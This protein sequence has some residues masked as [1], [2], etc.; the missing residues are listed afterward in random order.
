[1]SDHATPAASAVRAHH[2]GTMAAGVAVLLALSV[3]PPASAASATGHVSV[4][5][6]PA[7]AVIESTPVDFSVISRHTASGGITLSPAGTVRLS[8]APHTVVTLSVGPGDGFAHSGTAISVGGFAHDAGASPS[9][10]GA[11]TLSVAVGATLTVASSQATGR[12]SGT[13]RVT[14]NY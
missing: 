8:G 9:L 7:P 11:G 13:Y 12:Y 2:A 4:T 5:I 1:M 10:S 14:V 3:A 6:L